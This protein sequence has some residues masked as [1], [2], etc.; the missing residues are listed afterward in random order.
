MGIKV[1]LVDDHR[2][3][4]EGL[5]ILL[6]QEPDISVVGEAA[7]G[8]EALVLARKLKPDLV[9]MDITMPELNGIEA[10]RQLLADCPEAKVIALSIHADPR[11]V[12]EMLKAGASGYLL[13]QC[14]YEDLS[15]AIR[16]VLANRAYL[17]P[18]VTQTLLKDYVQ[19]FS[20]EE[21]SAYTTLS[22]R[23]REVLQLLAEGHSTKEV[24]ARLTVS[25]KTIETHRQNLMRKLGLGST[26]QL[27]KY[28]IREGLTAL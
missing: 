6:S 23:E 13:K 15:R 4:L 28:A 25:I 9:I 19:F 5:R 10:T 14:A 22:P 1:L 8:R 17:S 2:I 21:A 7:D 20:K 16:E 18:D 26:A 27:V 24:A 3:I 11:Y 12:L